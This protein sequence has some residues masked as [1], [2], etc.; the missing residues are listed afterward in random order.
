MALTYSQY[1]SRI[2]SLAVYDEDDTNFLA[3][4]PAAIEYAE[5]RIYRELN[6]LNTVTRDSSATVT[7]SSREFTLPTSI[8]RFVTVNGINIVTPVG[9]GV[10]T[11]TRNALQQVSRDTV[12]VLWPSNT[13]ASATTVPTQFAMVTDQ[14]VI[15]G[16]PPGAAFTAEVVGTIRPTAL[17]ASNTTTFLSQYLPDLFVAASMIQFEGFKENYGAQA[18]NPAA[19]ISWDS[20]YKELFD[21]ADKEEVRKRYGM[22]KW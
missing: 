1:L 12:D 2:A 9:N 10:S 7:A 19:A 22:G 14:T 3:N 4:L 16:P 5:N 8:G 17:S 20:Q 13:A 15:F 6:L 11:G 21:S 18:D